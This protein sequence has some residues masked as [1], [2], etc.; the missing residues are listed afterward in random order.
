MCQFEHSIITK[1]KPETIWGL[2]TDITSW[3]AWDAGIEHASLDGPFIAGTRGVRR[4]QGQDKLSF[5]LR[6]VEPLHGFSDVT[7]IPG[8]GIEIRFDHRLQK[9]LDGTHITHAVSITGPNAENFGPQLI[10]E[11]SQDIPRTMERLAALA[12]EREGEHAGRTNK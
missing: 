4:P 12:I 5:Q 9:A 1:A 3:T 8:A 10:A 11:L 6:D 7:D 2:Y